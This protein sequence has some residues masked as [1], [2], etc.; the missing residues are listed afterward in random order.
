MAVY[1]G[2]EVQVFPLPRNTYEPQENIQIIDKD[3]QTYIVKMSQVQ[4]TEEERKN[5]QVETGKKFDHVQVIKDQDLKNI[6]DSQDHKKNEERIKAQ[7]APKD[8][9]IHAQKAQVHAVPSQKTE[10]APPFTGETPAIKSN[11]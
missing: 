7:E 8:V 6:R 9:T 3:G 11:K 10:K 1:N 4:F 5:M 2:R